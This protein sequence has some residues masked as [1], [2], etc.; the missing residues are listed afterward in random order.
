MTGSLQMGKGERVESS[1]H[2]MGK[3]GRLKVVKGGRED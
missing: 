2:Q 1:S 3:G